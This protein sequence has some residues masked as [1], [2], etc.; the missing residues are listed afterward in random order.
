MLKVI[1]IVAVFQIA[2][3]FNQWKL[4]KPSEFCDHALGFSCTALSTSF[5]DSG[6]DQPLSDE[7]SKKRWSR[8]PI[9][10]SSK[11]IDDIWAG[12]S[13][14]TSH[15]EL[16]WDAIHTAREKADQRA[17]IRPV[18]PIDEQT[19]YEAYSRLRQRMFEL[20]R[21][22]N[23]DSR[24]GWI[25]A[26]ER[27]Q[28]L[29]KNHEWSDEGARSL[30]TLASLDPLL[31]S[32]P[33]NNPAEVNLFED[34]QK[35]DGM[36]FDAAKRVSRKIQDDSSKLSSALYKRMTLR[37]QKAVT[38]PAARGIDNN[39]DGQ[40]SSNETNRESG[41][42]RSVNI[43]SNQYNGD[44]R[45][46]LQG[47][48]SVESYSKRFRVFSISASHAE[49][50]RLLWNH[51]KGRLD[52]KQPGLKDSI[53]T[54]VNFE[55]ISRVSNP[56]FDDDLF[57][58]LARYSVLEGY[59]WQAAIAQPVLAALNKNFGVTVECFSSPLNN[60]LPTYCSFFPD[61]DA[62][63]GSVGSFFDFQPSE[64]SFEANPPFVASLM[65]LMVTRMDA[66]LTD[67]TGPMSFAVVVPAWCEDAHWPRL[68]NSNFN[69]GYFI[70]A[71]TEHSYC[72]GRQHGSSIDERYRP[73]PFDTAVFF[74]Q[75]EEGAKKWPLTSRSK[76]ELIEA[77]AAAKT[78]Q[79]SSEDRDTYIPKFKRQ[80]EA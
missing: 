6:S 12:F 59:G 70:V 18:N 62:A 75:N 25:R 46:S 60:Y 23:C 9:S 76:A 40:S 34:L 42:I 11:T 16:L 80:K 43:V 54:S 67:A 26:F 37:I 47:D 41:D 36:S 33:L 4:I 66:L 77:F 74:L 21:A 73:A 55:G 72:D 28:Y 3:S 50:L 56:E 15:S 53:G 1:T 13:I 7:I 48:A 29:S 5:A 79:R 20:V 17:N 52:P 24:R 32:L 27:W 19:R 30:E 38:N 63:F 64:G 44:L 35:L 8:K 61:T 49:K 51:K 69:K 2:I 65:V 57:C 22:E 45:V 58:L 68:L 14:E 10:E 78:T 71:A 31:P 39:R